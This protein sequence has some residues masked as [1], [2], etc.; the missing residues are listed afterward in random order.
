MTLRLRSPSARLLW[1]TAFT[2]APVLLIVFLIGARWGRSLY[3]LS[4]SYLSQTLPPPR[5]PDPRVVLVALDDETLSDPRIPRWAPNILRR[6]AHARLLRELKQ[7]GASVV[8]FDVAF[9]GESDPED[10]GA[11]RKALDAMPS[12]VLVADARTDRDAGNADRFVEP[13]PAL[14]GSASVRLASPTVV[15]L[16]ATSEVLGVQMEQGR[17]DGRTL[18]ALSFEAYKAAQGRDDLSASGRYGRVGA[19]EMMIIRWSTDSYRRAFPVISYREVWDGS[20]RGKDPDLFRGRT[21]L[22]G[23]FATLG[24]SDIFNTPA[25]KM[26]GVVVHAFALRTLLNGDWIRNDFQAPTWGIAVLCALLVCLSVYL[27]RPWAVLLAMFGTAALALGLSMAA[28][29]ARLW[30]GPV[31][32]LLSIGLAGLLGFVYRAGFARRNLERF[33]GAEAAR[34]LER[35]GTIDTKVHRAT[36]LFADVRGYTTLSESLSPAELMEVLNQHFEWMDGIIERHGGRVDKHIGDALMAVF[37]GSRRGQGHAE[38][39]VRAALEM[40]DTAGL[41]KGPAAEIEF[42]IGVHTGEISTGVL[43]HRERKQEYGTIGDAVNVAARLEQNTRSAAVPLLVS[44]ESVNE[45][46]AA[47]RLRRLEPLQL[48]GR[49]EPVVVYTLPS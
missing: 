22:I 48:K 37:E 8:G 20:W 18:N 25:G 43:G 47:F 9:V 27:L 23:S 44:E 6:R 46:G 32:P 2:L 38:R 11:L 5:T 12:T 28:F 34:C 42:G 26:P 41:R 33:A 45:F 31:E 4:H 3:Y 14:S 30:L 1:R 21:V 36:V 10:D 7:A 15:R 35:E 19:N 24:G 13:S 49:A 17:G 39:A 16:A 40:I 29:R